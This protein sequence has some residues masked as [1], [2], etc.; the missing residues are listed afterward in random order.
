MRVD[1]LQNRLGEAE[2]EEL[3]AAVQGQPDVPGLEVAVQDTLLVG[4]FQ[5]ER[6]LMRDRHRL[7][8]R[9]RTETQALR[10]RLTLDQLHDED[11]HAAVRLLETVE[12]S[13]AGMVEGGEDAGL[14][15]Q[16]C[17][18]VGLP[19]ELLG[20]R[21]ESD[22]AVKRRVAG[23]IDLAHAPGPEPGNDLVRAHA[24]AG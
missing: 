18:A 1:R 13:D 5:R 2:I 12:G 17:E 11:G 19:C 23:A 3:D 4:R 10:E 22:L 16:A 24:R 21:L 14:L 8:E 9:Q 6:D 15:P 20:Q 7:T